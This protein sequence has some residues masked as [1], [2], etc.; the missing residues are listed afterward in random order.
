MKLK[1]YQVDAFTDRLFSGNPAAVVPLY[2]KWIKRS[3]MQDIAK[4][5]NLSETAF[6]F[7]KNCRTALKLRLYSTLLTPDQFVAL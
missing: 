6:Y 7:N 3:I 5:N 2:G 1:I 4:E